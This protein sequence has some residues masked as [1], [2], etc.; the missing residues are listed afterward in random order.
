M[1]G[2]KVRLA[3]SA[4]YLAI[5]STVSTISGILYFAFAARLL[6]TVADLGRV[7]AITMFSGLIASIVVLSIPS[8]VT[9]YYAELIGRGDLSG[10]KGVI[11][12]GFRFGV[13]A[14]L[15]S[16]LSCFLFAPAISS[17]FLGSDADAFLF[18]LLSLDLFVLIISQF[19][20]SV[21]YG[22]QMFKEMCLVSVFSNSL[23]TFATISLLLLG[24]DIPGIILGW[25]VG[26]FLYLSLSLFYCR[27][28]MRSKKGSFSLS[29][30]FRYSAP[31]YGSTIL[32]YFQSTIDRYIVLGLVGAQVL[33]LYSPATAA[34]LYVSSIS[35]SL[36]SA[37]FPKASELFGK[38][39]LS[40]ILRTTR[41]TSRY[42]ALIYSP[43]A[44]GLAATAMP[45][46]DLFAGSRYIDGA[47]ALA[48]IAVASIILS[49]HN[50]LYTYFASIGKTFVF[51]VSQATAIVVC[52]VVAILFVPLLGATGAAFGR[53]ALTLAYFLV[54]LFYAKGEIR[55]LFDLRSFFISV[56]TSSVMALFVYIFV[57]GYYS[58]YMLPVYILV[59]ATIYTLMLKILKV[60]DMSDVNLLIAFVPSRLKG[61]ASRF[62]RFLAC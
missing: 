34:V 40:G 9:K 49:L 28:I 31:I 3:R 53:A 41:A 29:V 57:W 52:T 4:A 11:S 56:A 21:L 54:L 50:V 1:S 6:P 22:S 16:S 24:F 37:I 51:F 35:G 18:R 48:I 39:D 43:L 20:A 12:T 30:M 17:L 26:D 19:S 62:G 44:L 33:G 8:A 36:A 15:V 55:S 59:G 23:K 2:D 10:A 5:Q 61:I 46:I 42:S 47:P 45:T 25:I 7:S 38:G 27:H 32:S 60:I 58:K 14:A 13:I